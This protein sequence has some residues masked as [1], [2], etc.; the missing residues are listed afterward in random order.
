MHAEAAAPLRDADE[1]VD[2]VGQLRL[3]GRELVDDHHQPGEWL[4]AGP[5][6]GPGSI[7]R[8]VA[9]SGGPQH[10]LPVAQLG[11]EAAQGSF[12]EGVVE[13]RDDA[14]GVRQAGA[15]VERAAALEVDRA[16]T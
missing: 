2:E 11:L 5:G 12:G 13:V 8:E 15:G 6:P 9:R 14:D 16:R 3:Q 4:A 1:G 7:A 10:P